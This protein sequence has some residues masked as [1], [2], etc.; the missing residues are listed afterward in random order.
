MSTLLSPQ[1]TRRTDRVIRRRRRARYRWGFERLEDRTLLAPVPAA[2]LALATLLSA[3]SDVT[4]GVLVSGTPI[5]FQINPSIDSHLVARVHAPGLLTRL[6]VLDDQGNLLL[7]SDGQSAL[8]PD[9]R[10]DEHVG[11]GT[12]Y[13]ELQSLAGSGTYTLSTE[14]TGSPQSDA[15]PFSIEGLNP[16]SLVAGHFTSDGRTELAV[17]GY[18]NTSGQGV[19]E[20]LPG[21]GDGTLQA[22]PPITLGTLFPQSLVA[23]DFTGDGRTDLAVAGDGEVELLLGNGDG[24]FQASTPITLGNLSPGA[25]VAGDFTGDGRTE[26]AVAG[27]DATSGQGEVEVL[28]GQGDGTFQTTTPITLGGLGQLSLV[29]GN[30][31]GDGRTE[32][33]VAGYDATS[34]QGEVEVLLS[35]GDGTFH[36]TMPI[37]LGTFNPTS[38]V[39]GDFRGDGRTDL[40]VGEDDFTSGQ[41]GVEV[42]LGQGDGT[43]QTT[44]PINLGDLGATLLVAANFRGDGRDD[45]AVGESEFEVLLSNGDGTFRTTAPINQAGNTPSSV[46]AGDFN[47]DGREDLACYD[48]LFPAVGNGVGVVDVLLGDGDGTFQSP[49]TSRVWSEPV[50]A[51][52]GD[53]NGDGLADLAVAG[54]D[55]ASGQGAVEVLP[56]NGDG[57]FDAPAPINLGNLEPVSLV[58]GDFTG[59]GLASLAVAGF[60]INSGQA[61]VEVLLGNGDGTFQTTPPINLGSFDPTSLVAGDISGDDCTDLA[62]AG[63][64][65]SSGQNEVEVLLGHGD[66]TFQTTPPIN[67]GTFVPSKLVAG[68][69]SGDGR[70][71]LALA[72]VDSSSGQNEVEVLPASGAGAFQATTIDLGAFGASSLVAGDWSGDGRTDLALAGVDSSSGQ[73]GVEV[74]LANGVGTFQTTSPIN[75]DG[76][77][78]FSLVAGDFQGDGRED[79]AVYDPIF[80]VQGAPDG[81]TQGVVDVL[82]GKGDGT[83]QPPRPINLGYTDGVLLV[84]GNFNGAGRADLADIALSSGGSNVQVLPADG[85][86][87]FQTTPPFTL[88]S[89]SRG[90][91]VAGDFSGAGRIDLAVAGYDATSGQGEVD[92]LLGSGD[93]TFQ[94]P[95]P[96]N[97]GSFAGGALVAGDFNGDGRT[98]LAMAGSDSSSGQSEVEVLLGDGDGTFQSTPPTNL[99]TLINQVTLV[100]G[101]FRGDGRIDLAVEGYDS[102]FGPEVEVLLGNGDGTFQAPMPINLGNLSPDSLVAGDFTGNGRTDLAVLGNDSTF[103]QFEAEVLLSNG[104]GT[105]QTPIP[106]NLGTVYPTSFVAGDFTGAGR[107]DLAVGGFDNISGQFEVEVLP[108]NGDGTFESTPPINVGGAGPVELLVGD[109]TGD[110]RTTLAV[111]GGGEAELLPGDGDG[112]FQTLT[113]AGFSFFAGSFMFAADLTGDGRTDLVNVTEGAGSEATGTSIQVGINLGNGQ[114]ATPSAV[115]DTIQHTPVVADPGDGTNDVFSVDQAGNILWRK[116][117]PAAPGSYSPP[118]TINPGVPSRDIVFVPTQRGDLIASVDLSDNAVSLYAYQAGQFVRAGLLATG[119][120]PTQIVAGDVTGDGNSDLVVLDEGDGT[121]AVYLGDGIGGFGG[122][123]DVPIGAGASD[124]A[125]ADVDGPGHLDLVVTNQVTGLVS[126]FPGTGAGTFGAPSTY[127]AGAG[128][129]SVNVSADG[130]TTSVTSNEATAGVAIGTFTASAGPSLATIDPGTNSFG[131]LAGVGGGA[132]ANPVR[133]LTST[134]AAVI[135]AADFTADGLSDL[136][137]L[138]SDGVTVYLNNGTGGFSSATT[139]YVGPDPTGLTVADVNGDG[140]LDLLIGDAKGDVL[141]LLGDG[142]GTFQPYR[143]IDQNVALAV[144][145]TGGA[146]PDFIFANQGTNRVV[147]QSGSQFTVLASLSTGILDPGAVRLADL[148]NNGILDLI[149][150]N[151]GGNNVLVYPGLGNGQFGPELNGG[152]GFFTGTDPVSVTVA[153]LTGNG[154]LDLIVANE[155]SNDVAILL[156]EPTAGGGFTFV[157]SERLQAG[158][159]PTLTAV[160]YVGGIPN[161]LVSDGGANQVTLLP[162]VGNGFFNDQNPRTFP[163]GNDPTSV[164]I[165]NFLAGMG[166]EIVTINQGSNDVTVISDFNS[167]A[168]VFQTFATGG[169]EPVA[170]FAVSLTGDGLESLAIANSGDGLFT[171]LGGTED[172]AV[173]ATVFNPALTEPSALALAAVSGNAVSFYATTAGLDVAFTLAFLLPG[174]AASGSP[175]PGGSVTEGPAQ[176]L[177]PEGTSLALIGTLLTVVLETPVASS[178]PGPAEEQGTVDVSILPAP[179]ALGQSLFTTSN[180]DEHGSSAA[181]PVPAGSP[182]IPDEL[183][184]SRFVLGVEEVFDQIRE[185]KRAEDPVAPGRE[186]FDE[187]V[188]EIP[189]EPLGFRSPARAAPLASATVVTQSTRENRVTMLAAIDEAIQSVWAVPLANAPLSPTATPEPA[190]APGTPLVDSVSV[191]LPL[192]LSTIMLIDSG[193]SGR[194]GAGVPARA[195]T[196]IP[197]HTAASSA[198]RAGFVRRRSR[199]KRP[200]RC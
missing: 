18:D 168:P 159:G 91:L 71:D 144:L 24:T 50:S 163:V 63:V 109:F 19:V 132:L 177:A 36:S 6:S 54:Y 131:I 197:G 35:N 193:H 146:T 28:L 3:P 68:D 130:T 133:Y 89:L 64:D 135:R 176:L 187:P 119:A 194:R 61:E 23:G 25:L 82:L 90:A 53:W 102:T 72:G 192:V 147:V 128:P 195:G 41:T 29:A 118:V 156:N 62:L 121:A 123:Y 137:V 140:K 157:T 129:Y 95:T 79:L 56:G 143:P 30:F 5:F 58:T 7:Q 164:L 65:D 92:V 26:L 173:E 76:I 81:L 34:G 186:A 107:T 108:G 31:N 158:F 86:G 59:D 111:A 142:N 40:A 16:T 39:A 200:P 9:D 152:K 49:V 116:G 42:L 126:V 139:Y 105:F 155:G 101:D 106:I 114:F 110:G 75:L 196:S 161:I 70:T 12:D 122:G 99:G 44:T 22:T 115:A 15:L 13:L 27:Y 4:S 113:L 184:W 188:R 120:L 191:G 182:G 33:A 43:F 141:V 77:A 93:G 45:L 1:R 175:V 73:N 145:P 166:T 190:G 199:A 124:I 96:T 83:F 183:S 171:L 32:L 117:N 151:G 100:T 125:L 162:G 181:G 46:V 160:Q 60:D 88:A 149:V 84:T 185:E 153:D 11:A 14:L 127:P 8:N 52:T 180:D 170:A 150:V 55:N 97:L 172:L 178:L 94:A 78:P 179:P 47:G 103:S 67:L 66:G 80:S 138:G 20:V 74:L 57:T 37:N 165:G 2:S 69:W 85:N 10:V 87:S 104:D 189:V 38:L 174:S 112:T 98:D 134:P 167:N 148:D 51:V 136:A 48:L 198:G 154:R 17:A 21:H 169:E